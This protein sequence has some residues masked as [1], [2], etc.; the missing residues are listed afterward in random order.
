MTVNRRALLA[1]LAAL[2]IAAVL[3]RAASAQE[4]RVRGR[5]LRLSKRDR[6]WIKR[7][8]EK[9]GHKEG[10]PAYKECADGWAKD[11]LK[12]RARDLVYRPDGP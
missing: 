7:R 9:L 8:C 10:T 11:L 6:A 4:I 12:Q 5:T 1:S 2:P 3:P